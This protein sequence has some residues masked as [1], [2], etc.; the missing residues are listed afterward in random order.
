MFRSAQILQRTVIGDNTTVGDFTKITN[1][2]IGR[3]VIIGQNCLIDG[4]YIF[5]DTVIENGCHIKLSILAEHVILESDVTI[6]RGVLIGPRVRVSRGR[7]VNEFL[8]LGSAPQPTSASAYS[9]TTTDS[10][11]RSKFGHQSDS[12][13]GHPDYDDLNQTEQSS[14]NP[15]LGSDVHLWVDRVPK[16]EWD[17]EVEMGGKLSWQIGI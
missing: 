6:E 11:E 3:N 16:D 5:E 2:V 9:Y 12:D 13:S 7:H 10:K 14:Q 15:F 4:A 17:E 8:K 1:S